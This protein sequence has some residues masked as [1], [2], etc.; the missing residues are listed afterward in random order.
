MC[1]ILPAIDNCAAE[2]CVSI[3]HSFKLEMLTNEKYFYKIVLKI[4]LFH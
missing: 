3:F 1:Y 2:L 4:E